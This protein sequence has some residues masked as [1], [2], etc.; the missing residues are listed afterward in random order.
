MRKATK[1]TRIGLFA[2]E[3]PRA[4][5]SAGRSLEPPQ[6]ATVRSPPGSCRRIAAVSPPPPVIFRSSGIRFG[7]FEGRSDSIFA[8]ISDLEFCLST[9]SS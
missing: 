9:W 1:G 7:P 2:R 5:V 3:S 8:L 4:T 6:P